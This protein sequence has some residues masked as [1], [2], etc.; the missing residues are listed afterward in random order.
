M[1]LDFY[2]SQFEAVI[3]AAVQFRLLMG[4]ILYRRRYVASESDSDP[5]FPASVSSGASGEPRR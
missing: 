4:V 5:P 3:G 2:F 1:L